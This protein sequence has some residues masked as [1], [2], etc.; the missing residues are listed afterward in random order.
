MAV[1][2]LWAIENNG[3][4]LYSR[5]FPTVE[6]QVKMRMRKAYVP[7]PGDGEF[8]NSIEKDVVPGIADP[9][10]SCNNGR[11]NVVVVQQQ[12]LTLLALPAFGKDLRDPDIPL[13]IS[14]LQELVSQLKPYLS[15]SN[16][17]QGFDRL[18]GVCMPFGK[19]LSLTLRQAVKPEFSKGS[20]SHSSSSRWKW[21]SARDTNGKPV[22]PRVQLS[23]FE[24]LNAVYFSPG[25]K[26]NKISISGLLHAQAEIDLKT[27]VKIGID[28]KSAKDVKTTTFT[29]YDNDTGEIRATMGPSIGAC[30]PRDGVVLCTYVANVTTLPF[31]AQ[32]KIEKSTL[33][34]FRA[35]ISVTVPANLN[36]TNLEIEIPLTQIS[37]TSFHVMDKKNVGKILGP[38]ENR[39]RNCASWK[40]M[41]G[42]KDLE[43]NERK[44]SNSS[45]KSAEYKLE[46]YVRFDQFAQTSSLTRSKPKDGPTSFV[47]VYWRSDQAISG[48][49]LKLNSKEID[50]R[51]K[52]LSSTENVILADYD[53][54]SGKAA[55]DH[56]VRKV[57]E[58][59]PSP[60]LKSP[61]QKLSK[62]SE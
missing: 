39:R 21:D 43:L 20:F 17:T 27:T 4:L 19:C 35:S 51:K 37:F 56:A 33:R 60:S 12:N 10:I 61:R 48:I 41:E 49:G 1:R 54:Y 50:Y 36:I 62:S 24:S 34:E 9:L 15:S 11:W 7:L 29:S 5:R 57:G 38:E 46:F 14:L 16:E 59:K 44:N 23:H 55:G 45:K 31:K 32:Y 28:P 58:Q 13:I 40:P 47:V 42:K 53:Y 30:D 25:C 8:L 52:T 18:I 6:R 26:H 3:T 22:L 2:A